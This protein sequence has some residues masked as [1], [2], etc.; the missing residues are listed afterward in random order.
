MA[1]LTLDSLF[2]LINYE[3]DERFEKI[4]LR[5]LVE[6]VSESLSI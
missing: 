6:Y 5:E 3:S 1:N 2:T 4:N